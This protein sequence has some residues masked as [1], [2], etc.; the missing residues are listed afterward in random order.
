MTIKLLGR[1]GSFPDGAIITLDAVT[2]AALVAV[3]SATTA[4][5]GGFVYEAPGNSPPTQPRA[6]LV[7][8][9][10]AAELAGLNYNASAAQNLAAL[11]SALSR[12]GLVTISTPG[13]YVVGG[14]GQGGLKFVSNSGI[15]CAQGVEIIN[16]NGTFD[17]LCRNENAYSRGDT[18]TGVVSWVS[19]SPSYRARVDFPGIQLKYPVGSWFGLLN[20]PGSNSASR[21]W[22]GVWQVQSVAENQIFFHLMHQPPSG[23]NSPTGAIVYPVDSNIRI[24]GG[25]WDGNE[26]GQAGSGNSDGD[27]RTLV[28]F[29]RNAQN[30]RISGVTYRRGE[31]WCFGSNNVRGLTVRDVE[32][33]TYSGIGAVQAH[34]IVH[35]AG[36]H[37]DVLI[38]RV[39]ADCDDNIIGL[40][41]DGLGGSTTYPNYDPGDTYDVTIR[42]ICGRETSATL[43]SLWGNTHYM[44]HSTLIERVTGKSPGGAVQVFAPY[45]PTDMLNC[46]GGS[47][48]IRDISGAFDSPAVT[49]RSD[50]NWDQIIIDGIRNE[51]T[52]T[53]APIVQLTRNTTT[54][55]IKKLDIRNVI[56]EVP[57]STSGRAGPAILIENSNV[58]DLSIEGLHGLRLAA[59]V[60]AV[61]FGGTAGAV[62]RAVVEKVG[63]NS[64]AA[65]DSF[66]VSCENTNASALGRLMIRDA[67]MVGT[68]ASGGVFRQSPTG[69][70]SSVII[71]NAT[72]TAAEGVSVVD[73]VSNPATVTVR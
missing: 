29:F 22:Q 57:G 23:G 8:A 67:S 59:G 42:D 30:V 25:V 55:T 37:R 21:G 45:A 26:T 36:G 54:Q 13:Q 52:N 9:T 44:H 16:A 3:G 65:G 27:P 28:H 70:V 72:V 7:L 6:P 60:S 61:K 1:Y 58:N 48:T 41:L 15:V 31:A 46:D 10:T 5:A 32:A 50:G 63:G 24:V 2:E 56:G 53:T 66:L 33:S 40:T 34:D 38:E 17:A 19:G 71:D 68:S 73:N 4:L 64:T 51:S 39:T 62:L 49:I 18:I 12:G 43:V 11:N 47:L 35:L 69:R 20:L 14:P